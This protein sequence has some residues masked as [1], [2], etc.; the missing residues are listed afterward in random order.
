MST[1][2]PPIAVFIVDDHELLRDGMKYALEG[3]SGIMITGEASNGADLIER[4]K[5][6]IP[7][8]IL[9]DIQMPVMNGIEATKIITKK[10]PQVSV[11]AI[12]VFNHEYHIIGM[13][14]AGARGHLSKGA[15]KAEFI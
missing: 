12:S 13:I 14:L 8:V 2:S 9:M 10:Y 15:T 3:Q 5:N 7:D 1:Y 11:I 6:N 4:I